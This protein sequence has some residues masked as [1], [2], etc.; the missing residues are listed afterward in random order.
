MSLAILTA[1]PD[2]EAWAFGEL[3]ARSCEA[4]VDVRLLCL[5][6]GE[7]GV[8]HTGQGRRG[9]ALATSRRLELHAGL[10]ALAQDPP[11]VAVTWGELPDAAL[12][13]HLDDVQ[14]QVAAWLGETAP[15]VVATWGVAG[16]YGHRDHVVCADAAAAWCAAHGVALWQA[17]LPPEPARALGRRLARLR[18]M[19]LIVPDVERRLDAEQTLGDEDGPV[20]ELWLDVD[21][22]RK[23]AAL[24]AHA[25]QLGDA[26]P[27][28]FV[29]PDITAH[30]LQRER[31]RL[32]GQTRDGDRL[33]ALVATT[34][35]TTAASAATAGE[36]MA[37]TNALGIDPGTPTSAGGER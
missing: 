21:A 4:S 19:D 10:A 2:D 14:R 36:M 8:D 26:Q 28:Q 29:A 6:A 22:P 27:D 34:P 30:L 1:H 37:E 16:G 24:A 12:D 25:S 23:R 31:Y 9:A 13:R 20:G 32:V 18:R 3:I 5:T 7:R 35:G 17:C 11:A 15:A 33:R